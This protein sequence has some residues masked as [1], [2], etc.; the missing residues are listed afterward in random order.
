[1]QVGRR[2]LLD[3]WTVGPER[4]ERNRRY[5]NMERSGCMDRKSGRVVGVV[6][7]DVVIVGVVEVEVAAAA[8]AMSLL[9]SRDS[10][11]GRIVAGRLASQ[12]YMDGRGVGNHVVL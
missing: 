4:T 3:S 10:D 11:Q 6:I 1:V 9:R 5:E 7:V 12:Q 8:A 2:V